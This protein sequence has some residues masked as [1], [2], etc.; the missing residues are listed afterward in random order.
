LNFHPSWTG[1]FRLVGA[2]NAEI[3]SFSLTFF[4]LVPKLS[5]PKVNLEGVLWKSVGILALC[6][7][8]I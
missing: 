2:K 3:L 8:M 6:R 5:N 7:L 4:G 1:H